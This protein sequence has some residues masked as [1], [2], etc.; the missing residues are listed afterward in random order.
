MFSFASCKWEKDKGK[1]L[2][3]STSLESKQ[4]IKFAFWDFFFAEHIDI[5]GLKPKALIC[6]PCLPV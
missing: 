6:A 2:L 4:I 5:S 3:K 1:Q